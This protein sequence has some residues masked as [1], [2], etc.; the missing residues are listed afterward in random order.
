MRKLALLAAFSLVA[1]PA[2]ALPAQAG[3]DV[4]E[5]QLNSVIHSVSAEYVIQ[6]IEHAE[7][8]N[9]DA[10]LIVINTPGGLYTSMREIVD[11][12][13]AS[14]VPVIVYVSPTGSHATSAG[15]FILLAAD[16]AVM[17]PGTTTGAASPVLGFQEMPET[18]KKKWFNDSA[19]YL[20]SYVSKRGRNVE[21]AE[22]AV[23]EAK[24][25]TDQE[26]LNQNLIDVVVESREKLLEQLHAREIKRFDGRTETLALAGARIEPWQM[27]RRQE[28]LTRLSDP[29]IA[30]LLLVFGVLGLYIELNH[31]GLIVPGTLG[32]ICIVLAL[33]S[34][35]LL[36]VNYVAVLMILLAFALFI[37]EA[38]FVSHGI[39]AAGGVAA[40]VLGAL[41][42]VD[43]P[44]IPEMAVRW[45]LA[46]AVAV[47]IAVITVVLLRFV[48]RSF[49]WRVASGKESLVGEI[50]EVRQEIA[51]GRKGM[52]FV[53][54]EWWSATSKQPI[55]AGQKVRVVRAQGLVLEVEPSAGGP[56]NPPS[57]KE[58]L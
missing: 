24:S 42:L 40:M 45:E 6:G 58:Q 52:V 14:R 50:G 56:S 10:V 17:A 57:A 5:I 39:L 53:A 31:P 7:K 19:A 11:R 9:A 15:F 54:G 4:V 43:S 37:L 36:P 21:V 18:L 13:T 2:A 20:R 55:A 32:G 28:F 22:T 25:F 23:T 51:N 8:T 16:V 1:V 3:A 29:N 12:I 44:P 26:A 46:L 35:Q 48:W 38:K 49:A 41:M 34:M 30:F 33:F 47:P 27:T